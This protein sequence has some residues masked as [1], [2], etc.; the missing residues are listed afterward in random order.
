MLNKKDAVSQQFYAYHYALIFLIVLHN[1]EKKHS[2][3]KGVICDINSEKFKQL[4]QSIFKY[5]EIY[6]F[7]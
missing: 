3:W 6:G 7:S 4:K 1:D 2:R 5:I